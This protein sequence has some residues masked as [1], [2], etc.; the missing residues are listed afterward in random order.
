VT[1]GWQVLAPVPLQT[2]CVHH[3]PP[4]LT[5]EALDRHTQ[6]WV[7]RINRSGHA[8][9]TPALLDGNWMARVSIGAAPTEQADVVLLW[10]LMR[11]LAEHPDENGNKK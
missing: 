8:Y 3:T 9:L 7:D 6:T 11:Q 10:R 1:P 4:G 5:G 2:V